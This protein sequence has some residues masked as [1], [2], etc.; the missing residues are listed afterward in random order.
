MPTCTFTRRTRPG[1]CGDDRISDRAGRGARWRAH[2]LLAAAAL[3]VVLTS[4][5][6]AIETRPP[7]P[8]RYEARMC[9]QSL[10]DPARAPDCGA[11]ELWMQRAQRA[12]VRIADLVYRLQL[13]S[14]QV[15]VVLM[16]GA[17]QIDGFTGSYAWQGSTL[18]IDDLEKSL[19]YE[20]QV[21]AP[22]PAAAASR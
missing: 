9:T 22:L 1:A 5:A 10:S 11:V 13:H 14:S 15:D 17:M 12:Q 3:S 8:G 21:G 4:G 16:H 6:G 2:P 7:Q 19:R 20:I 18:R